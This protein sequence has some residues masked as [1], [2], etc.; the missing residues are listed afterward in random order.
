[1]WQWVLV[2]VGGGLRRE[3]STQKREQLGSGVAC[4]SGPCVQ[5]P[6]LGARLLTLCCS[7]HVP[8]RE[9]AGAFADACV[10]ACTLTQAHWGRKEGSGGRRA[11][12]GGEQRGGARRGG[13]GGKVSLKE[14]LIVVSRRI[15]RSYLRQCQHRGTSVR[16]QTTK[17]DPRTESNSHGMH[18]LSLARLKLEARALLEARLFDL[19]AIQY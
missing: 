2:G 15:Q 17:A 7:I 13:L 5:P 12:E 9:C 19:L 16:G 4:A 18:L 6:L 10:H 3:G 1:M 8:Q 14:Q 11:R